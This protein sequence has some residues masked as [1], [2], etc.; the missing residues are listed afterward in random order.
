MSHPDF[1]IGDK[2]FATPSQDGDFGVLK[3]T[4]EQQ[5]SWY[6]ALPAVFMP[7]NGDWGERGNTKVVLANAKTP[8]FRGSMRRASANVA[9]PHNPSTGPQPGQRPRRGRIGVGGFEPP[10]S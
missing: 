6:D 8:V 10:T 4:L 9:S 3:L 5:Q 2:V 7:A 1:R